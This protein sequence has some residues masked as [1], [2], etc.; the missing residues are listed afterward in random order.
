MIIKNYQNHN[1]LEMIRMLGARKESGMNS[2]I[3]RVSDKR[4]ITIPLK[5]YKSLGINDQVECF[6]DNGT[7]V[8]RPLSR[9]SNE[10]SVEILKDLMAQ[11]FVGDELIRKFSEQNMSIRKAVHSLLEEADDI[12]SGQKP[13]ASMADVFGDKGDV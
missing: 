2:R 6:L 5:Y 13:S 11:G 4:Q 12:A 7:L 3:I 8:I 10:F 9:D 1:K